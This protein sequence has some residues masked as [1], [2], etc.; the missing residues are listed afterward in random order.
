M[1]LCEDS[2]LE[3]SDDAPNLASFIGLAWVVGVYHLISF[4][5]LFIYSCMYSVSQ[6][7]PLVMITQSA[8]FYFAPSVTS[9]FHL[10]VIP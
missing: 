5:R 4:V 1:K 8:L 2:Q 3:S 6:S 7:V 10:T 9:V